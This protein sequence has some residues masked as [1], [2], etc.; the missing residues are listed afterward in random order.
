M[1]RKFKKGDSIYED[2]EGDRKKRPL[3]WCPNCERWIP[4]PGIHTCY[5]AK[6]EREFRERK[7]KRLV[8]I[9]V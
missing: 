6:K 3:T 9:P 4:P 2:F 1:R 7:A 5:S 8:I